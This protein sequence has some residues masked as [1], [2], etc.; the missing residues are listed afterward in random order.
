MSMARQIMFPKL[1]QTIAMD[2][3]RVRQVFDVQNCPGLIIV[4]DLAEMDG[5]FETV[6]E[7]FEIPSSGQVFDDADVALLAWDSEQNDHEIAGAL[8]EILLRYRHGLMRPLWSE[9]KPADKAIWIATARSFRRV[10]NSLGFDIIRME[11]K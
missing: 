8:G 11:A 4:C 6:R 7:T 1:R 2:R 5:E 3:G 10:L 9:R